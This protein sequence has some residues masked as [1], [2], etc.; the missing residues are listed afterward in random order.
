MHTS[1]QPGPACSIQ[2]KV[3]V[4]LRNCKYTKRLSNRL[5]FARKLAIVKY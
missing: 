2:N 1:L 5:L 3:S 4:T